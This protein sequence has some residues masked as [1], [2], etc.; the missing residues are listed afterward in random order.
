MTDTGFVAK[1]NLKTNKF[2]T[3]SIKPPISEFDDITDPKIAEFRSNLQNENSKVFGL[4]LTVIPNLFDNMK[5][6]IEWDNRIPLERELFDRN[7]VFHGIQPSK[8][9]NLMND[10]ELI[11]DQYDYKNKT[12]DSSKTHNK[13]NKFYQFR[14][15][16]ANLADN[17]TRL[18]YLDDSQ[19]I[20]VVELNNPVKFI[21][22]V[23]NY[24]PYFSFTHLSTEADE[25]KIT[26]SENN[27]IITY[28]SHQGEVFTF[29]TDD[30][31]DKYE[32]LYHDFNLG[33]I[34]NDFNI[35]YIDQQV[36]VTKLDI[37][38]CDFDL[39]SLAFIYGVKN[40]IK[41]FS[42]ALNLTV[43]MKTDISLD[44]KIVI[45]NRLGND[46]ISLLDDQS[47]I[48]LKKNNI[49]VEFIKFLLHHKSMAFA[50]EANFFSHT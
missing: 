24:K 29:N 36:K 20:K 10:K 43:E 2:Q 8:S 44:H 46:E 26:L 22:S 19:Q 32:E 11:D 15:T 12:E 38:I 13:D 30:Q 5:D 16:V 31:G 48:A 1:F 21:S 4:G 18:F 23:N 25:E 34:N 33:A 50:Y 6:W 27:K 17:K 3:V 14:E 7:Q 39:N 37:K 9:F 28:I 35:S 41:A 47:P 40:S 49:R 42:I 45:Y